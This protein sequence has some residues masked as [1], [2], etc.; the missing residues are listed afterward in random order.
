MRGKE[1][2]IFCWDEVVLYLDLDGAYTGVLI[3]TDYCIYILYSF[4]TW[5]VWSAYHMDLKV[6]L[7]DKDI[8]WSLWQAPVGESL[9]KQQELCIKLF[10]SLPKD[11]TFQNMSPDALLNLSRPSIGDRVTINQDCLAWT[12]M[13]HNPPNHKIE[14]SQQPCLIQRVW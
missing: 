5:A 14:W 1:K 3:Y 11:N 13:L 6:S 2:R 7:I 12:E 4:G 10:P 9:V 8:T